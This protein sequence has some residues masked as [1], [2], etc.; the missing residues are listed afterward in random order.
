[1]TEAKLAY[2]K[3]VDDRVVP[4]PYRNDALPKEGRKVELD[5][6]WHRR[7]QDGDITIIDENEP[8]RG[9]SETK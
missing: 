6:Y 5:Q 9:K 8:K 1:M 2:V 4:D 3:P 7:L